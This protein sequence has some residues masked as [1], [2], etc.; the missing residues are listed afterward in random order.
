M[1]PWRFPASAAPRRRLG[2]GFGTLLASVAFI[3]SFG[4]RPMS[5][6][7]VTNCGFLAHPRVLTA[8][9]RYGTHQ[10]YHGDDLRTKRDCNRLTTG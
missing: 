6:D 2:G 7:Q 1:H 4:F 5:Y 10:W 8:A 9:E 3:F